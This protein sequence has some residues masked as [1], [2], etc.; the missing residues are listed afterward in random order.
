MP[1]GVNPIWIERGEERD[2][3]GE[4]D[5]VELGLEVYAISIL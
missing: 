5:D 1:D 3:D 2:V 4:V